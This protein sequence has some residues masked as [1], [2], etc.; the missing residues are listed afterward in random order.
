MPKVFAKKIYLKESFGLDLIISIRVLLIELLN[1]IIAI[2][3]S[4]P[5]VKKGRMN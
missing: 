4:N 1:E 2:I 3:N 5:N